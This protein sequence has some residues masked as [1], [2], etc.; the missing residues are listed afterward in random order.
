VCEAHT[1]L[2]LSLS[3]R[4]ERREKRPKRKDRLLFLPFLFLSAEC[5]FVAETGPPPQGRG[6]RVTAVPHS[7]ETDREQRAAI[8]VDRGSRRE[9][10]NTFRLLPFLLLLFFIFRFT[11]AK[12]VCVSDGDSSSIIVIAFF[13]PTGF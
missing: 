4:R 12:G 1:D 7:T 2:S 5:M 13:A 3:H 11:L 9:S 8:T 10:V 6:T